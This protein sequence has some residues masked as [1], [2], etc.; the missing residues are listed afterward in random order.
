[1]SRFKSPAPYFNPSL[2][3]E[4]LTA[5][6]YIIPPRVNES[7]LGWIEDSGRFKAEPAE[8]LYDLVASAE[9]DEILLEAADEPEEEEEGWDMD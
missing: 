2:R 9:L 4:L 1:M 7:L 5:K 8:T 6:V 3:E